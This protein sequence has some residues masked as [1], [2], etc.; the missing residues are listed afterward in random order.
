[1]SEPVSEYI[2]YE[3]DLTDINIAS[4]EEVRWLPRRRATGIALPGNDFWL[5]DSRVVLVNHFDGVGDP[6]G[7]ELT[8]DPDVVKLCA[9]AF[10]AVW[11]QGIPHADYRPT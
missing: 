9:S 11:A 3:F 5:F 10:E 8:T 2:R 1:M 4:G 6:V 7:K